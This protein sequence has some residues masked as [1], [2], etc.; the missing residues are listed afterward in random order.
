MFLSFYQ[1]HSIILWTV[2]NIPG[3]SDLLEVN[4]NIEL[5]LIGEL[6]AFIPLCYLSQ[7]VSA[8]IEPVETV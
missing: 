3:K 6:L 5:K 8:F 7:D 2:Y 1:T 4:L